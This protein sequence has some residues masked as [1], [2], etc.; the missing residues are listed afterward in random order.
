LG[1]ISSEARLRRR[2]DPPVAGIERSG[3]KVV[4]GPEE[5][6][7]HRSYEKARKLVDLKAS[8]GIVVDEDRM[9]VLDVV[10]G[11][12]ADKAGVA[13]GAHLAAINGRKANADRLRT[14][15][16]ETA[17]GGKLEFLMENAESYTTHSLDYRG[18]LRYARLERDQSR[19]DLLT[20]IFTARR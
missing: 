7:F 14:A 6:E 1:G 11:S 2:A 12:A 13:P 17:R 9:A 20:R 19:P 18:G 16:A 10:P 5:P 4:Y 3:W 8:A 15:V